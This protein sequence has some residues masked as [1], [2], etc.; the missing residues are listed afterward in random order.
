MEMQPPATITSSKSVRCSSVS[1]RSLTGRNTTAPGKLGVVSCYSF[2]RETNGRLYFE[3]SNF[4][5]SPSYVFVHSSS[6]LQRVL[7]RLRGFHIIAC[8]ANT[9]EKAMLC[10]AMLLS[11][12]CNGWFSAVVNGSLLACS[13]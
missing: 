4:C 13:G 1:R 9:M 12:V 10:S 2:L 7:Y 6:L 8:A 5:D 11:F 3:G